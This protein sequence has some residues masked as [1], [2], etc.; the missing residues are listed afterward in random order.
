MKLF[1]LCSIW[2]TSTTLCS[3]LLICSSVSS[4]LF[5]FL[6]VYFLISIIVFFSCLVLHVFSLLSFLLCSSIP[7]QMMLSEHLYNHYLEFL[8]VDCSTPLCLVFF[9]GFTLFLHLEH[10]SFASFCITLCFCFYVLGRL[11]MFLNLGEVALI[12]MWLSS[13]LS[14]GYQS[15]MLLYATWVLLLSWGWPL[16]VH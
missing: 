16:W 5:W 13:T 3:S 7:L 10:T 4:N 11:V 15:Y 9:W 12:A 14:S 6:L 2:A 8:M 1:F